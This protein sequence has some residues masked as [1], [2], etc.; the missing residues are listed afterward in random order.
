M[1]II[2]ENLGE[3]IAYLDENELAEK[4]EEATPFESTARVWKEEV[5]FETPVEGGGKLYDKVASGRVAYWPPGKALCLFAGINQPYGKVVR[6]GWILGPKHFIHWVEDGTPVRVEKYSEDGLEERF[7]KVA[8]FLRKKGIYAAARVWEDFPS[9][10]GA[11]VYKKSRVG[12]DIYVEDYGF[13]IESDPLYKRDYGVLDQALVNA[14]RRE[15]TTR[16]DINEEGYI[17]VSAVTEKLGDLPGVLRRIFVDYRHA[18]RVLK[19]IIP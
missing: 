12:F 10:S 4:F 8:S 16:I 19:N 18:R 7:V 15:I 9:V 1:R 5:Y 17:I 6:L 14:L 13:I 2:F 11:I 3:I